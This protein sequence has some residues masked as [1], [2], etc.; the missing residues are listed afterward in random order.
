MAL[1]DISNPRSKANS[2]IDAA[3]DYCNGAWET[4]HNHRIP[5][6]AGLARVLGVSRRVVENWAQ[7]DDEWKEIIEIIKTVQEH[8]LIENALIGTFRSPIAA[9]ML[10]NH[11]YSLKTVQDNI[12]SDGS[13][14]PVLPS[15]PTYRIVED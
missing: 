10:A 14:T 15:A 9:L 4:L 1:V 3:R 11:G 13:M 5:S 7:S 2:C 8:I 6:I 12:S